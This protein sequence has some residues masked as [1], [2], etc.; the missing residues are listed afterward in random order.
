MARVPPERPGE[1]W[2]AMAGVQPAGHVP[3]PHDQGQAPERCKLI[4]THVSRPGRDEI[5]GAGR[6]RVTE[7][8]GKDVFA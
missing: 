2:A 3:W 5:G 1:L 7:A 4:P 8:W 6:L